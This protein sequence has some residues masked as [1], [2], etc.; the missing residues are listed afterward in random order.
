MIGPRCFSAG[1]TYAR[2]LVNTVSARLFGQ[3]T[4][5]SSS[6]KTSYKL[7]RNL[8]EVVIST[9]SR[10]GIKECIEFHGIAPDEELQYEPDDLEKGVSTVLRRAQEWLLKTA[11]K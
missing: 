7:P 10:T 5:G 1:E 11:G 9:R 4:A 6:E 2:D 8:G 3:T